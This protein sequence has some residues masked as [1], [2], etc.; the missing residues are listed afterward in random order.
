MASWMRRCLQRLRR[1]SGEVRVVGGSQLGRRPG[2]GALRDLPVGH[3][4]GCHPSGAPGTAGPAASTQQKTR[5]MTGLSPC[6]PIPGARG[7]L[8]SCLRWLQ[9][10]R[11][12]HHHGGLDIRARPIRQGAGRLLVAYGRS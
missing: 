9:A 6:H 10:G 11:P 7:L 5:L 3:R 12:N 8:A 1:R 2:G 4:N